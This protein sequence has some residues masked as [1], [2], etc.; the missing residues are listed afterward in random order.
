MSEKETGGP[1]FPVVVKCL[2]GSTEIHAG[3]TLRDWFAGKWLEGFIA[4]PQIPDL[5]P[6]DAAEKA[7]FIADAMLK[8]R[9]K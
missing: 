2:D 5:T 8:E 1:A 4:N 6:K 7:Y 9:S 3:M